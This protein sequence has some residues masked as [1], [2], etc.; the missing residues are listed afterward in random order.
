MLDYERPDGVFKTEENEISQINKRISEIKSSKDYEEAQ[1][2][3]S[4]VKN[5]AEQDIAHLK[6]QLETHRKERRQGRIESPELADYFDRQS[7]HEKAE[8]KRKQ[9]WWN[10][11]IKT[12]EE[13]LAKLTKEISDLK[14]ERVRRSNIL[15]RW[16]FSRM[17]L[18]C[19]DGSV[20]S[21]HDIFLRDT[22][23]VPPSGTG[24]CCA[25]KLLNYAFA[26]GLEPVS[27]AEFWVGASPRGEIRIDGQFYPACQ[28]KCHP[29]LRRM[30]ENS[31][32]APSSDDFLQEELS[33]AVSDKLEIIYEDDW[34][35]AANKP[36]GLITVSA[37]PKVDSLD[38]RV[39]AKYPNITGPGYV[40]R[41]DQPTSGIVLFAKTKDAHKHMQSLFES[42]MAKKRYVAIL[43]GEPKQKSGEINLPIIPNPDDR[44][45]QMIDFVRGKKAVTLYEVIS[46]ETTDGKTQTR[47]YFYPQTGRTHQLRVHAAS[48]LGLGC[49]IVGDNLYGHLGKRLMLH[50][51]RIEFIHPF[52]GDVVVITCPPEF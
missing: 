50:A 29:I 21:V 35:I 26:N 3:H 34:I 10:E 37:N 45:R 51:D 22:H 19:A 9:K 33:A 47:T 23:T 36:S 14:A 43:E 6:Q 40:H 42:R 52:T 31:V 15:Q 41:L 44:P 13:E 27:M 12:C 38:S 39:K 32:Y 20:V 2:N 49:P 24:D 11:Q 48:P 4:A 25:P 46:S 16:L 30:L 18:H 1:R 17:R 8:L 7:A 5:D 28:Q